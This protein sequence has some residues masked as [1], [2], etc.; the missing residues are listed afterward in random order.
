[1]SLTAPSLKAIL[2]SVALTLSSFAIARPM[3]TI[4]TPRLSGE[5]FHLDA[6]INKKPTL[7]VFWAT[8]CAS[9]RHEVP[10]LKN[11]FKESSSKIDLISISLDSDVEKL[12]KYVLD[13][14]INYTTLVDPQGTIAKAF[15]IEQTPSIFAVNS[16][17]QIVKHGIHLTDVK[18]YLL[19]LTKG[20]V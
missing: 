15:D 17:G 13:N 5:P 18:A 14:A 8:W 11:F 6:R 4:S 7:I 20:S 1:M 2:F 16:K 12:K 3:P 10:L 9:C 19:R